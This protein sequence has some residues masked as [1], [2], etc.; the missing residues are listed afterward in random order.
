MSIKAMKLALEALEN[1]S[2]A[3]W[4]SRVDSDTMKSIWRKHA[5]ALEGLQVLLAELDNASCKSVQKRLEAQQPATG[6][7]EPYD[8]GLLNDFGGG[9]VEWWQDYIRAEL[10]NAHDFYQ[11]QIT[12]PQPAQATQATD[13]VGVEPDG[14]VIGFHEGNALVDHAGNLEEGNCLFLSP[15]IPTQATQ[16]EVTDSM[17]REAFLTN[18]FTIKDGHSDLKPYVYAA[19][20]S[21]RRIWRLLLALRWRLP[22]RG[23]ARS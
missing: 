15:T 21:G 17:I 9:N 14:I 19:A 16:A 3:A 1:A 23:P 6:E 2:P 10:G 7:L 4:A 20:H 11:S 22:V 18:G 8:A 13:Y 5:E 12:T